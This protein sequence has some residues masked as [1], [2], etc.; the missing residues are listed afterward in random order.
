MRRV[1]PVVAIL[2]GLAIAGPAWA[3]GSP[4]GNLGNGLAR[5]VAPPPAKAGIRMTQAPLTI[6]DRQGRVLVDVYARPDASLQSVQSSAAQA[7][8]DKVT[9]STSDKAL[10][11]YVAVSNI[12][13]LAKA[14]G[15]ASV[16]QALKPYTNVGA[17]TSQGVVTQRIDRVPHGIDGRGIT[18][19]ALSDS[20]DVAT[21]AGDARR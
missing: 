1:V 8:F 2:G 10:E 18:V 17:A 19:G 11:G 15:V 3:D 6:R 14:S 4:P 16:S 9:Q 12:D 20:F 7:G 13:D 21:E 5:L